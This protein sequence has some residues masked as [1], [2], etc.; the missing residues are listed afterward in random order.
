LLH[1]SNS[2]NSWTLVD[3]DQTDENGF[4]SF[5]GLPRGVYRV[6]ME[7]PGFKSSEFIIIQA[8]KTDATYIGQNFLVNINEKTITS[9]ADQVMSEYLPD[10][11]MQLIVYPNPAKD[12]VRINGLEGAYILK[13]INMT[14]Q[15]VTSV[16]GTTPELT[17]SLDNLPSGMYLLRIESQGKLFIK[18]IIVF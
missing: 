11:E 2:A 4:Y 5:T 13:I 18:K 1:Q 16:T 12:I 10:D 15:V 9:N 14:G 8:N 3:T 7:I 17:L 6:T